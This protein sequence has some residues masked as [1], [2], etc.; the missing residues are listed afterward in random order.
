MYTFKIYVRTLNFQKCPFIFGPLHTFDSKESRQAPF[1]AR[2]IPEI[3]SKI[4]L[5]YLD[6]RIVGR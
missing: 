2:N 3:I 6:E 1:H 4:V 5:E